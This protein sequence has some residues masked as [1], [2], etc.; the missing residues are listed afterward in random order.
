MFTQLDP[1]IPFD[2]EG[3]GEGLAIAVVDYGPDYDLRWVIILNKGGEV[4]TVPNPK[5]RGV[6][7]YTMGR[8]R[9]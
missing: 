7:N 1:P 2:V 9:P 3:K 6:E 8:V 5:V 4:W